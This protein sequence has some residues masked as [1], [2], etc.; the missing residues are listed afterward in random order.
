M[1]KHP[2]ITTTL[3][4]ISALT[5]TSSHAAQTNI[6]TYTTPVKE[7]NPP[8]K[9]PY[10]YDSATDTRSIQGDRSLLLEMPKIT[11]GKR[12]MVQHVSVVAE[13]DDAAID[14]SC[15]VYA[16]MPDQRISQVSSSHPLMLGPQSRIASTAHDRIAARIASQPL[17]LYVDAGLIPEITCTFSDPLAG[18]SAAITGTVTGYLIDE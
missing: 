18:H 16:G 17:T 4:M 7:I 5:G 14:V 10:Q 8:G 15:F 9:A 6:E 2:I 11:T 3:L 12:L 1:S 13:T